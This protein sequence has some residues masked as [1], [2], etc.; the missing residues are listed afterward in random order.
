M[1]PN[2]GRG[3]QIKEVWPQGLDWKFCLYFSV[4]LFDMITSCSQEGKRS[5]GLFDQSGLEIG[6]GFQEEF[7]IRQRFPLHHPG[8]NVDSDAHAFFTWRYLHVSAQVQSSWCAL[9]SMKNQTSMVFH[10][11]HFSSWKLK[12]EM[13]PA[14]SEDHPNLLTY[15][16][17]R[18]VI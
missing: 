10:V 11:I 3:A 14:V 18:H 16:N 8:R 17:K 1:M 12:V 2:I 7:L 6:E 4:I 13:V 5:G 9:C 15:N